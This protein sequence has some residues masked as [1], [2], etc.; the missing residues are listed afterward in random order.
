MGTNVFANMFE[1]SSKGSSGKSALPVGDICF[2]PPPTPAGVEPPIPYPNMAQVTDLD[3]GSS[4]VLICNKM[5]SLEKNS[6]MKTSTGNEAAKPSTMK[7]GIISKTTKG[8][9]Y[10]V[11][12]SSDVKYEGKGVCRHIDMTSWNHGS[13]SGNGAVLPDLSMQDPPSPCKAIMEKVESACSAKVEKKGK[14][15]SHKIDHMKYCEGLMDLPTEANTQNID[16]DS[17]LSK[18]MK[19]FMLEIKSSKASGKRMARA[20]AGMAMAAESNECVNAS[21]C[22][23]K[24]YKNTD[25]AK[26]ENGKPESHCCPGQS[27]HHVIPEAMGAQLNGLE[28][29]PDHGAAP[30][31]CVEGVNN[32]HGTH[33]IIHQNLL[34]N[35]K[36]G[37]KIDCKAVFNLA[38]GSVRDTFP[39]CDK[40]CSAQ[41]LVANKAKPCKDC[42]P[43]KID[44]KAGTGRRKEP[45]KTLEGNI[46]RKKK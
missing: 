11:Q 46:I 16:I 9:A 19:E 7:G 8:K 39:D 38:A 45:G 18:E 21:R 42:T 27:G 14:K 37:E 36:K 6:Y 13:Q 3:K 43:T 33:G 26:D 41:Q 32:T 20:A 4:K 35:F 28:C 22:V 30:T 5:A 34:R 44:A 12:W 1:V 40:G 25:S 29:W 24:D 2:T 17:V 31:I 15:L 23:F 10:Y